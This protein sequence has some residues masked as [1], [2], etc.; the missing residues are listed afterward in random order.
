MNATPPD[1]LVI[2]RH[3][4]ERIL[5]KFIPEAQSIVAEMR[6]EKE[7]DGF[8]PKFRQALINLKIQNWAVLYEDPLNELKVKFL[9]FMT[10]QE[11]NDLVAQLKAMTTAEQQEC[12]TEALE[13]AAIEDDDDDI[14][15]MTQAQ[16]DALPDEQR[17]KLVMQVQQTIAFLLPMVFNYLAYIVHGKSMYQLVA[18]AKAEVRESLLKA[19]QID[20]SVLSTIPYF[21]EFNRR[22]ADE[23]LFEVQ[24]QIHTYR[25]KPIF[26]SRIRYPSLWLV[27]AFLD[28]MNILEEFEEDLE[29]FAELCQ[30]L[31][32]Y[33]PPPE[34][35]VVDVDS[36][37][38]RLK[39]YKKT[40]RRLLP[41]PEQ[42]VLVKD[43]SSSNSPP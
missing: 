9:I 23:G 24:R 1:P 27:F 35:D 21:I 3:V 10:P 4:I 17:N 33:G 2:P 6:T 8:R 26:V 14:E 20:K 5:E 38:S 43:V 11:I 31:R 13:N 12:L 34:E 19:I 36:F 40:S 15:P 7:G 32:V 29:Y 16:F 42:R 25:Q 30:R 41:R 37:E 28:E 22:A 39:D 18:E